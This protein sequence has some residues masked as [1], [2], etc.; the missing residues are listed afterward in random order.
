MSRE[1]RAMSIKTR[2]RDYV[3]NFAVTN[4]GDAIHTGV[5][6]LRASSFATALTLRLHD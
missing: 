2:I 1:A 6:A 4:V 5:G 3:G